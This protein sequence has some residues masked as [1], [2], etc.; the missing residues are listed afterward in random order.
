MS[1]D[2]KMR[3]PLL[4]EHKSELRDFAS[5][6]QSATELTMAR[7]QA[8]TGNESQSSLNNV[9]NSNV[10]MEGETTLEKVIIKPNI[11]IE[12][13]TE[14]LKEIIK[15]FNK[16]FDEEFP[17]GYSCFVQTFNPFRGHRILPVQARLATRNNVPQLV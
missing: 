10:T 5:Q 16:K 7:A 1:S 9:K 2:R 13:P 6:Q 15:L 8:N 17:S 3:Q 11:S 12:D 14:R 4:Q